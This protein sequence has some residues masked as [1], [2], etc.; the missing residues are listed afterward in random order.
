MI[1]ENN[2]IQILILPSKNSGFLANELH[3]VFCFLFS[4]AFEQ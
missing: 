2:S 1:I 4:Y 3:G